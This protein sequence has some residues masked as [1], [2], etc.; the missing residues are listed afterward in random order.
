MY[1]VLSPRGEEGI[2]KNMEEKR[3]TSKRTGERAN[4]FFCFV[5]FWN[6]EEIRS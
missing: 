3:K 5:L 4:N 1:G 6:G 2:F